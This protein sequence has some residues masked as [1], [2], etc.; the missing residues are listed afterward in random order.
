METSSSNS[1]MPF[2]SLPKPERGC[3]SKLSR[4]G[5]FSSLKDRELKANIGQFYKNHA[6][7]TLLTA[8]SFGLMPLLILDKHI[9]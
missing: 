1:L 6:G 3:G 7:W 2:V 4:N 9:I 8:I 5:R